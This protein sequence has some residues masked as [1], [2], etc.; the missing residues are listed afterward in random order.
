[1]AMRMLAEP[2][3]DWGPTVAAGAEAARRLLAS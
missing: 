1:V 3:R 2:E